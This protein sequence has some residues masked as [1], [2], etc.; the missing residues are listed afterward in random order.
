MSLITYPVLVDP[1]AF[2]PRSFSATQRVNQRSFG[3]PFGGSEQAVDMLN[4]RWSFSIELAPCT[5]AQAARR[6][7]FVNALRGLVNHTELYHFGR[8][9]PIGTLSGSPTAQAAPQ[10]AASVVLNA[11]TGQTLLAGDM[12]GINGLLLQ[13]AADCVS[14]GGVMTV[15]LTNRLRR[16]VAD[17]T[18]VVWLQPTAQFR[19][20]GA[21]VQRY[22]PSYGE[23]LALEFIEKVD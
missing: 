8:Q 21:S 7:A 9:V 19:L 16:A 15:I 23:S 22:V 6:E 11:T 18:P 2:L 5:Q 14:I 4:D 10:G 1:R 13:V 20:V 12:I 17:A 3:S